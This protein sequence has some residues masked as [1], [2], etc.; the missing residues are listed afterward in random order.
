MGSGFTGPSVNGGKGSVKLGKLTISLDLQPAHT[1][2]AAGKRRH[3][4]AATG[5]WQWG[6]WPQIGVF[7]RKRIEVSIA[8]Q[9]CR[10]R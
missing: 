2:P 1:T 10:R 6:V 9:A 4:G 7:L 3:D 5:L 8:A